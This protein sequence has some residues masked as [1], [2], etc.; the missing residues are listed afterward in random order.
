MGS[1]AYTAYPISAS[2]CLHT[3]FRSSDNRCS[4]HCLLMLLPSQGVTNDG[5]LK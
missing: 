5:G 3:P 4:Q 1:P 2:V